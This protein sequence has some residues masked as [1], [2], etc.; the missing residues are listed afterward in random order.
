MAPTVPMAERNRTRPPRA[1]RHRQPQ[2]LSFPLRDQQTDHCGLG[3]MTHK[4]AFFIG[5]LPFPVHNPPEVRYINGPGAGV[6]VCG[7]R[8]VA[9]HGAR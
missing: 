6:P 3:S 7:R 9:G 8:Y 2:C 1:Q 5:I 4:K